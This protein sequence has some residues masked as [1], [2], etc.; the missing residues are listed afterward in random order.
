MI[1]LF[2][3]F[4]RS[5]QNKLIALF[6]SIQWRLNRLLLTVCGV[7]FGEDLMIVGSFYLNIGQNSKASIGK[8]FTFKSGHGFN[9]LSR[10][11]KGAIRVENNAVLEIGDF[12]GFSSVCIWAHTKIII[13]NNVNIGADT[14]VMDSNAHSLQ[15]M[16]RREI[17]SDMQ[18]KISSPIQIQ[19]DVLV[20]VRCIILKGV[21]IGARS[22]IGAGSVVT[23]DVP[24]DTIVAGNPAR[25]VKTL[26]SQIKLQ[27]C[28]KV[29]C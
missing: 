24:P 17:E 27:N 15:Y 21:T 26:P 25:V 1:L 5:L 23:S 16:N 11:I 19:D 10:N 9:P 12:C 13:G 18:D 14:I 2:Y 29:D 3:N 20:G 8:N 7:S 6:Y 28:L 22:I 4:F